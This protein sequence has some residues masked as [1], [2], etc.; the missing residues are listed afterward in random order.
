[1]PSADELYKLFDQENGLTFTRP[2]L[3]SH[4]LILFKNPSKQ[5]RNRSE[6][7]FTLTVINL[8]DLVTATSVMM[9][10][11][12]FLEYSSDYCDPLWHVS[13]IKLWAYW[14]SFN[15]INGHMVPSI[16]LAL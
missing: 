8:F 14:S 9:P 16:L 13:A 5:F 7:R 1:M 11:E 12:Y 6:Q 4:C 3:D 10:E 15:K 2:N